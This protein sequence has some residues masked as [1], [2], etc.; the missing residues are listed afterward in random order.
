M[1]CIFL[2]MGVIGWSREV[3][4]YQKFVVGR[5]SM[6]SVRVVWVVIEARR[7]RRVREFYF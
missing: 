3:G 2:S 5:L 6:R 7:Y 4:W 1:Q